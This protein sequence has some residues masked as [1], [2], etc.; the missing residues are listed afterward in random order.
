MNT[1]ADLILFNGRI[2][3]L[4]RQNPQADAVAIA[5]AASSPS[6]PSRRSWRSPARA[7]SAI[8]LQ[9]PPRHP[10]P[11]RQPHARH[12]RRP[13]LQHGAALGRRALA[14]RRHARCCKEQVDAHAGAAMG[15]RGRR[16]HR[17]PVRREAPAD[18][19]RDQRRRARHAGLHPAPLRPRP[20][21]RRRPAR[22]RLHQGHARTRP[23]ARSSATRSGN[24]TGLLLAKPNADDPVR[25]PGQGPEAAARVPEELDPPL[26]ARGE[27]PRR[28][29]RDRRRR[30]LPELSRTTTGSSRSCTAKGS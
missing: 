10:R 23:A 21:Q 9:G 17:A 19:R 5:T 3:T 24:P 29:Q 22:R 4:D 20:A 26:H 6:A 2:T 13:E 27:P 1:T 18:A 7:R 12:P 28:H 8:D 11:D 16:L 15:A 30:R 25:D 14:G